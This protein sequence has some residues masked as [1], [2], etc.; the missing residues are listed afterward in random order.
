MAFDPVSLGVMAL[1]GLLGGGGSGEKQTTER[2]L[3]PRLDRYVY[4]P[5]SK[6]GL[7]GG[8]FGLL[9]QQ[10]G[11][12]GLNDLQRQGLEMQRQYLM[13]PQ[14]SQGFNR[15]QNLGLGLLSAGVAGNPFTGGGGLSA[16]M[17]TPSNF[18][19]SNLGDARL[20]TALATLVP[21][22]TEPE[23]VSQ[24]PAPAYT[25]GSYSGGNDLSIGGVSG[26]FNGINA[27]NSGDTMSPAAVLA[28]QSP[29]F[30]TALLTSPYV[31]SGTS[32]GPY[33]GGGDYS[34]YNTGS[35]YSYGGFGDGNS[36]MGD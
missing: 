4:G 20:P 16:S 26:G 23:P 13:S 34:G 33:S 5:D 27:W 9:Q 35:D 25:S 14:Y 12:G 8:A 36:G 32:W 31:S 11:Q 28:S 10:A 3:D 2:K 17:F 1:G 22:L 7:L 30:N 6:S 21:Q 19:Y 15:L 18:A 24:A 29:S